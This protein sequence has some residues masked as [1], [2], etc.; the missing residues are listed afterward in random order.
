MRTTRHALLR[1]ALGVLVALPVMTGCATIRQDEIGVKTS[2]GRISSG[3]LQPGAQL[4]IPGVNSV[5]RVPARVVNR[6]VRLEMPSKE[7][8]NVAAEVSILYRA[9]TENIRQILETSG[10]RYEDD[11]IIPVFR[12]AAADV[13]A[14]YMAKDMHSGTRTGIEQA[15]Q[16]RMM[17][18][19]ESRGFV[20]ENVL[21]KSI[22]SPGRPRARDRGEARGRTAFGADALC[23]RSR[24]AG[25]RA[26]HD[27]GAGYSRL[28]GHHRPGAHAGDHLV[29]V[30][31][32]VPRTGAKP[33]REGDRDRWQGAHAAHQRDE[34]RRTSDDE[35]PCGGRIG[36]ATHRA[37]GASGTD[38]RHILVTAA[39][40]CVPQEIR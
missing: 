1:P 12:S 35:C 31:R 18:T 24:E 34:H 33:E 5:L 30:H 40:G 6:E 37:A 23:A 2:F 22:R 36:A 26:S 17:E 9:K 4:V 13:S 25:G 15:I 3:P 28:V 8:L 7:G 20:V 11:V 21:L 32:G 29:P 39:V 38:A 14:R 27:R 16:A 10:V 19:L